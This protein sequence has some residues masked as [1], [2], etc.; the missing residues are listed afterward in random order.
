MK[1]IIHN[2]IITT[3]KV[4]V[5][6]SFNE[7]RFWGEFSP[8]A[9]IPTNDPVVK[10]VSNWLAIIY[11]TLLFNVEYFDEIV[12]DFELS[13]DEV[14]FFEKTIDNGMAEFRY[15][16]NIPISTHVNIMPARIRVDEP[17]IPEKGFIGRLLMNGGG[18][19]GLTSALLLNRAG[20]EFDLY[21]RGDDLPQ[22]RS[23]DILHK[24]PHILK[25]R[26]I[27]DAI[28]KKYKG[29]KPSSA[30]FAIT[31][32]FSAYL[33]GKKDIITSNET[34]A[35]E[36]NLIVDGVEINHQYT[37]TIEFEKDFSELL[38]KNGMGIRY[39]SLLRP[40]HELQIVKIFSE[41]PDFYNS[42][43]SCNKAS[44][45][46]LWCMKCAKCAFMVLAFNAIAPDMAK[47]VFSID[48]SINS[49]ALQGYILSLVDPKLTKPFECVGTLQE[50][51]IAAK[52][53]LDNPDIELSEQM[54]QS[55][56]EHSKNITDDV[57]NAFMQ[58]LQT[59]HNIPAEYSQVIQL[60]QSILS[61]S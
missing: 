42:F 13:S 26:L 36:S 32:A 35:N 51:Q 47:K 7:E 25:R 15:V 50:C 10:V 45:S 8:P 5:D 22:Q 52:L 33:L 61:K 48:N 28:N 23:A 3:E 43:V 39:F 6:Y 24:T 53:I 14:S 9:D 55:F 44:S 20:I 27:V 18:K 17:L 38:S 49:P 59:D 29:H 30:V 56:S 16:N 34:S 19:D 46:G 58:H 11:S 21:Q 12:T 4:S 1:L 60:M 31:A 54:R 41:Q 40:L 37:K 2:P 57:I